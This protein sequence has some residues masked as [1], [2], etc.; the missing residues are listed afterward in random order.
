[1]AL[2]HAACALGDL[3]SV[4]RLIEDGADV[5]GTRD[6]G[7]KPIIAAA[8]GGH[9]EVL[10]HLLAQGCDPEL[11]DAGGHTAAGIAK[12]R[13][14]QRILRLLYA[15]RSA[16]LAGQIAMERS[17]LE[18]ERQLLREVEAA[19]AADDDDC[20]EGDEN[21][22]EGG[23]ENADGDDDEADG[24]DVGDDD[25]D[26]D[27]GDDAETRQTSD[28]NS[29][30]ATS[31][32]V[33]VAKGDAHPP[34]AH[35]SCL[36]E[37]LQQLHVRFPSVA[38]SQRPSSGDL[39]RVCEDDRLDELRRLVEGGLSE[40][41][42]EQRERRRCREQQPAGACQI[43]VD[44]PTNSVFAP[45]GHVVCCYTCASRLLYDRCPICR[46]TIS[47]VIRTFFS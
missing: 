5:N 26:D 20:D 2:L 12:H 35:L 10:A 22:D 45:C 21:A 42:A 17:N 46:A 18:E 16:R 7:V 8:L 39:L 13:G 27:D 23:D 32:G 43:C 1:M 41:S 28:A 9:E 31:P 4:R 3:A 34:P 38:D 25:D 29:N 14:D 30:D 40:I 11:A 24:S 6:A 19:F 47:Q 37:Q 15:F 44:N 36:F 33:L